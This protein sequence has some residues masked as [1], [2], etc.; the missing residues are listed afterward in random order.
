[1][2][3]KDAYNSNDDF[4]D[5][6]SALRRLS[7]R[8]PSERLNRAVAA[9]IG[10]GN[11]AA[12]IIRVARDFFLNHR[13]P[14]AAAA[15]LALA[16]GLLAATAGVVLQTGDA[17]R[18][19]TGGTQATPPVS[20]APPATL[21]ATNTTGA[22]NAATPPAAA[23]V[24]NAGAAGAAGAGANAQSRRV[25]RS[26]EPLEL[27][28]APDGRFFRPWRVQYQTRPAPAAGATGGARPAVRFGQPAAQNGEEEIHFVKLDLI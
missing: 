5:I 2:T 22:A 24:P 20:P 23:S 26:V 9:E 25:V 4:A 7:P 19:A 11:A 28:R 16:A 15:C 10:T 3:A 27:R 14:A 13:A 1:M 6:E 8:A 17:N 18:T 21:V 12:N